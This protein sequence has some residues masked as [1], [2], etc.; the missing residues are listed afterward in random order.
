M[1]FLFQIFVIKLLGV[2]EISFIAII[3]KNIL[4]ALGVR[5]N[6]LQNN[7]I[8]NKIINKNQK[9]YTAPPLHS[10]VSSWSRSTISTKNGIP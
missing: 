2:N 10:I 6:F 5:Q 7:N 4:V 3:I 9:K 1:I 8:P